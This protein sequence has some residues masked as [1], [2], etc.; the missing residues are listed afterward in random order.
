M[1]NLPPRKPKKLLDQLRDAVRLKH[2]SYSTEKTCVHRVKRY[3]LFH[4]KRHPREMGARAEGLRPRCRSYP[5]AA[6]AFHSSRT[7]TSTSADTRN[8][9]P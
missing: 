3:V 7:R 8:I 6:S 1:N 2:Y 4:N 5:S 9:R